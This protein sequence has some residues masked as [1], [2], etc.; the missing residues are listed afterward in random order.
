M[1]D[2]SGPVYILTYAFYAFPT[3]FIM[4]I[5]GGYLGWESN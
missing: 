3:I 4:T 1:I 5:I 2:W